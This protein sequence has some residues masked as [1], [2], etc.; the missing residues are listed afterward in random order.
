[1]SISHIGHRPTLPIVPQQQSA[2]AG[3]TDA[4]GLDR[5]LLP[6]MRKTLPPQAQ[7]VANGLSVQK[8]F[9]KLDADGDGTIT[10]AEAGPRWGHGLLGE[11]LKLQEDGVQA[12]ASDGTDGS[13]DGAGGSDTT[14]A[15]A[16]ADTTTAGAG[17]DTTT[18]GA[19]GTDSID[20][21]TGGDTVA[22]GAGG[23]DG[24]LAGDAPPDAGTELAASLTP[25]PPTG[26]LTPDPSQLLDGSAA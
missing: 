5:N 8:L 21:G 15:G 3:N 16:G 19:G 6:D 24:S 20:G 23:T 7:G 12:P 14:T 10:P 4:T 22:G 1:M 26:D 2:P 11:L 9:D 17:A 13:T 18:A 25:P